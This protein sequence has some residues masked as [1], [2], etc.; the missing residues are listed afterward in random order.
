MDGKNYATQ[1]QSRQKYFWIGKK[2]LENVT[3]IL[4]VLKKYPL[5]WPKMTENFFHTFSYWVKKYFYP[6][7]QWFRLTEIE[8]ANK[9]VTCY[10][11]LFY[12]CYLLIELLATCY[13]C[14][15]APCYLLLL[16]TWSILILAAT[17]FLLRLVTNNHLL[18]TNCYLPLAGYYLFLA[19]C[20]YLLLPA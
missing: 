19:T 13:I 11:L 5:H 7:Y 12:I 20:C 9:L 10:L 1:L 16:A 8:F 17:C 2:F 15:L 6:D 18:H 14:F 3:H 4:L